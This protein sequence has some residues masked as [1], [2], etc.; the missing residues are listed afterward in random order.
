ME[1]VSIVA[2]TL[3]LCALVQIAINRRLIG[4]VR[5]V[6]HE[7][8]RL[9]ARLRYLENGQSAPEPPSFRYEP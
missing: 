1:P 2:L 5:D 8:W 4:Q 6:E 9:R 7:V 3:A